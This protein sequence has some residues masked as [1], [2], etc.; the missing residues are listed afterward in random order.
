[1]L[2]RYWMQWNNHSREVPEGSHAFLG[3]SK[4][5][6][7]NYTDEQIAEAYANYLAIKRGTEL[8]A[9]ARDLI[10]QGIPLRDTKHTFNMYVNDCVF[11]GMKPEVPL[12][13]SKY[14]YGTAD[15]IRFLD[16]DRKLMIFDLKT[17]KNPASMKQL[18]IYAALFCL[19]YSDEFSL[20]RA[21]ELRKY[22]N[23]DI[24]IYTPE[25]N[26]IVPV[27]DKI[28]YFDKILTKLDKGDR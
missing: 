4:Y 1:M 10:K 7:L 27:M 3:A 25:I 15:A 18:I 20:M 24:E 16:E 17:G 8:H 14:C 26:E 9:L 22:Q 11:Y 28:V 6:W 5:S 19:E 23:N 13:Y 12:Y 2:V 21:I